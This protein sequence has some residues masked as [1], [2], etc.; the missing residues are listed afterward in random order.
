MPRPSPSRPFQ[1]TRSTLLGL[2]EVPDDLAEV[3]V[4]GDEAPAKEAGVSRAKVERVWQHIEELYR[5]GAHPAIQVSIRCRNAEVLHRAI[6]H[7]SGNSPSDR[8]ARIPLRPIE[9]DTPVN[10]FSAAKAVT[11]M[12]VHK[13]HD[14]GVLSVDDPVAA[15]IPEFGRAGKQAITIRRVPAPSVP[16]SPPPPASR[17]R[18]PAASTSTCCR[19]PRRCSTCSATR[20]PS[21]TP[22]PTPPTTPSRAGS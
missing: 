11:A 10:L 8:A 2:C 18:R 17:A 9:L 13:L 12:I 5:S 3:T 20:S 7:A 19:S 6:G 22:T 21:T 16:S 14:D 15:H 1:R 4:R